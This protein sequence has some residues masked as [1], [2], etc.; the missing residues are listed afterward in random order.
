MLFAFGFSQLVM[1]GWL[2]A[3]AVP[4]L[5]HLWTRR[6]Y[7]E[8]AWAAMEYLLAALEKNSRRLRIEQWLL[9]A[10]RTAILVLVVLAVAGP[11]M[12]YS[13][14]PFVA[15]RP[16]H[17]LI[18]IDG[19][20]SMAYRATDKS[21]F[22]RACELAAE[23]V[24]QSKQG[25]AFS[26]VL[27][28]AP[29]RVIVGTPSQSPRDFLSE[30]ENL[31]LHHTGADLAA[32]LAQVHEVLTT[33]ARE[34]TRLVQ[35][36]VY[37]LTD[38]GR[39]TWDAASSATGDAQKLIA[40]LADEAQLWLL[41]LGQPQTE[42]VAVADL[43]SAQPFFTTQAPSDFEATVKNFTSRSARRKVE[44]VIDGE[45]MGEQML[46]VPASGEAAAQFRHRFE[47]PG[48]H[49]IQVR[50]ADDSLPIDDQRWLA[51]SAKPAIETLIVNGESNPRAA[52]YLRFALDPDSGRGGDAGLASPIRA[53]VVSE[54]A[55]L[56]VDLNRYDCVFLSNVGQFTSGE[57]QVLRSYL[58]S[59][60]GLV[61]FLGDRVLSDRYNEEL[62]LAR[63]DDRVLPVILEQTATPSQYS[64]DPLAY[65]HPI[66]A[67]FRGNE[68]AGLLQTYITRYIRMRVIDRE[69]SKAEVALAFAETGDP[70][71]VTESI[72]G[73]RVTVVAVPASLESVDPAT[74]VPWSL[75]TATQ[76]FQPIVQ[77]TLAWTLRGQ[78]SGRNATA[79]EPIGGA[80][81]VSAANPSLVVQTPDDRQEQIRAVSEGIETR[82][83]FG[84]TWLSGIYRIQR[85]GDGHQLFAV[86]VDTAESDLTKMSLDELPS[87][88][89]PLEDWKDVDTVATGG[90]AGRGGL[91]MPLLYLALCLLVVESILAW[92]MGYRAI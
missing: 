47:A 18:V 62:G 88:I 67:V 69:N 30:L 60:G 32:T 9:L 83:S 76:S 42:N 23:I 41:D 15:G 31:K 74:K 68:G 52:N 57:A 80:T 77:E 54:T 85:P 53:T 40:Q 84:D 63:G 92:Y 8:V 73:G 71:I 87:G 1:L 91:E 11:Y 58:K 7:R 21:R 5:I 38:L 12:E 35:H 43:R 6:K 78:T 82:W 4:V 16:T 24:D 86:N 37:F 81:P 39:T 50:L 64:L 25:D 66:V 70:S 22:E 45:R 14:A 79:G 49:A 29:P 90:L 48:E 26:L 2:A 72:H 3:A 33:A 56:E 36:E 20:Y 59:G 17:K 19:S 61:F 44:L 65:R 13:A 75:M 46:E 34:Q 27:M 10:V 51:V 55:L 89:T 28:A